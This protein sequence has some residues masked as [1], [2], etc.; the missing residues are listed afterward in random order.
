MNTTKAP[1]EKKAYHKPEL[2]VYGDVK[3]LTERGP[4]NNRVDN[5]YWKFR[6]S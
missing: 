2:V 4:G 6:T 3:E 1:E 5:E